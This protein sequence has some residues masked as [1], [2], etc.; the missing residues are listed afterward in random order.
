M[1]SKIFGGLLTIILF[2]LVFFIGMD[3]RMAGNPILA[4]QV[5]LNG[6]KLGLINSDEEL[7]NLIDTEQSE[8]KNKYGVDKVYPPDGLDI[9]KIYTYSNKIV[10]SSEIYSQIKDTEPFTIEGYVATINYPEQKDVEKKEPV[11]LYLMEKD[12]IKDALHDTVA[13]FVDEESL[14]AYE[15][16]TQEAIVETGSIINS[17]YLDET[18]TV[19]PALISTQEY[20]FRNKDDLSRY[21]L[22]GTLE[23]Q[24]SYVVKE[25][26]NVETI[27][28]NNKLNVQELLIANPS[29]FSIDVLLPIGAKLNVGLINPLVSVVYHM[30]VVDDVSIP[31]KTTYVNDNTKYVDY[32]VKTTNGVNGLSRITKEVK[33]KNGEIQSVFISQSNVLKSSIDEVYTRGT[34]VYTNIWQNYRPTSVGDWGWPTITPYVITSNFKWRWGR[35]HKGIDI[36]GT[37]FGSPI[38][39]ATDGVVIEAYSGCPSNGWY[40]SSCGGGYGNVVKVRT[41]DGYVIYYAHM[42]QKINVSVGQE[43]KKN[44][45]LGYMGNSGSST[46]THLHFQINAP[47]GNAI[48]PCS[49]YRC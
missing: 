44:Q 15:K 21:L 26:D 37:G 40:G 36:S 47:D 29:L 27:A 23:E 10:E 49:I 39:S 1:K 18:V 43:V 31:Y 14:L 22:F 5:Y 45:I 7:F 24:K 34:K 8:L 33:Y 9:E 13:A 20:I 28:D 3:S 4:Y 48:D 6:E 35:M 41:A 25:G 12:F 11:Y 16:E 17:I 19:K 32:Q 2:V 42:V 38:Y 46:G 30:T